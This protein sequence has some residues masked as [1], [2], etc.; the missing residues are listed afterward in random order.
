MAYTADEMAKYTI[1]RCVRNGNAI[2]NL[3]LQKTL[4]YIQ[5]NFI[6]MYDK[7]AFR[8]EFEAWEYGPV[9]PEIYYKYSQFGGG[10]ICSLFNAISDIFYN[11]EEQDLVNDIVD[12]CAEMD[13]WD[14]V[15]SSHVPGGPWDIAY[16]KGKYTKIELTDMYLYAKENE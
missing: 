1:D 8:D 11:S 6:R 15:D 13:P 2:S 7:V 16:Q 10:P 3:Q 4:Y 9:I 12:I 5:L 14:L